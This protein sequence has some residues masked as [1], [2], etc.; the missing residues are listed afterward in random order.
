MDFR[1]VG[2]P[3]AYQPRALQSQPLQNIAIMMIM[4]S[5]VR[6]AQTNTPI[7]IITKA[8]APGS[9]SKKS[10]V[11]L[12][13]PSTSQTMGTIRFKSLET[14]IK[15]TV[16]GQS[17]RLKEDG[18]VSFRYSFI[19]TSNPGAKWWWTEDGGE[20]KLT[21]GKKG[22]QTIATVSGN[23]LACEQSI[24]L[25]EAAVDEVVVSAVAAF[26]KNGRDKEDEGIIGEVLGGV[27]GV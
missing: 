3:P 1:T 16:N 12:I 17:T 13:R 18:V 9:M 23:L 5:E 8:A 21:D 6:S 7:F 4:S 22:G 24:G 19:P 26:T 10:L 27:L 2:P 14:S 20:L 11:T 25:T 15:L